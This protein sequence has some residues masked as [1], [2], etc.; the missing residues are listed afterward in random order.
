MSQYVQITKPEFEVA[1]PDGWVESVRGNEFIYT[2]S[3]DSLF[4]LDVYSSIASDDVSRASGLDAIRFVFLDSISGKPFAKKTRINRVGGWEARLKVKIDSFRELEFDRCG[5]CISAKNGDYCRVCKKDTE[6]ITGDWLK[7]LRGL[8]EYGLDE[9]IRFAGKNPTDE[10][11]DKIRGYMAD[12][13]SFNSILCGVRHEMTKSQ[14]QKKLSDN[15]AEAESVVQGLSGEHSDRFF[16]LLAKEREPDEVKALGILLTINDHCYQL[17][18][19][20]PNQIETFE[21]E[22]RGIDDKRAAATT[23]SFEHMDW[24][25]EW[26][27]PMQTDSL[28]YVD[29]DCNMVVAAPTASGKTVV[30]EMV[31]GYT[32][33]TS[34]HSVI[35]LAPMKALAEEKIED[36]QSESHQFSKLNQSIM[37]GDYTMT[38]V[39]LKEVSEA[40]VII[41]TNEMLATR[42]RMYH[43]EKNEWLDNVGALIVDESHLL[44][45]DGRGDSTEAALMNFT[46]LNPKCRVIL[47]SATMPNCEQLARWCRVLNG[48]ETV[49]VE[50]D[51]RPCKLN[52]NYYK[53][54]WAPTYRDKQ[55]IKQDAVVDILNQIGYN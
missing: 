20:E 8:P 6:N 38:S 47:L 41:M 19:P 14:Y 17:D 15:F 36:F 27:N 21:V 25:F 40:R 5:V 7:K 45:V 28:R 52:K 4:T 1:L 23:E 53:H 2:F 35:Y 39:K 22:H 9:L 43:S 51:Y 18:V 26:F 29:S 33:A 10:Q 32:F 34:E 37:T 55:H 12:Y 24:D 50:S 48:K 11:K 42:A 3:L 31:M 49:L 46:K 54:A 16:E 44:G 30:A 13:F